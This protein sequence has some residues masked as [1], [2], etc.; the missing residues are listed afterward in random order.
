M[1][2][3][4]SNVACRFKRLGKIIGRYNALPEAHFPKLHRSRVA[5]ETIQK[6][7]ADAASTR[8]LLRREQAAVVQIIR[9]HRVPLL[10]AHSLAANVQHEHPTSDKDRTH[11]F[12]PFFVEK[13][14]PLADYAPRIVR[15]HQ[16]HDGGVA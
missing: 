10:H 14:L 9:L 15:G 13:I 7:N 3:L 2:T 11:C 8:N 16:P 5:F 12:T 1:F 6:G 4:A